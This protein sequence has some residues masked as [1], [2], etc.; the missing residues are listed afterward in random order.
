MSHVPFGLIAMSS[1]LRSISSI[2][3]PFSVLSYN[4]PLNSYFSEKPK[5]TKK[6]GQAISHSKFVFLYTD[7]SSLPSLKNNIY[8]VL[9]LTQTKTPYTVFLTALTIEKVVKD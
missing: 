6:S 3:L 9:K 5:H 2:R 7:L 8:E 1:K 4:F